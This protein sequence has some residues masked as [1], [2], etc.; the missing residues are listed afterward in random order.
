MPP[1]TRLLR[2]HKEV[3]D[4]P[5]RLSL[6]VF[7]L[8]TMS[9]TTMQ[10]RL[11]QH[12]ETN[13]GKVFSNTHGAQYEVR[14]APLFTPRPVRII[15]IG[16]GASGI[17]MIHT[18]RQALAGLPFEHIVFEKNKGVGGTWFENR[19]PGCRADVPSHSYQ[20]S[21]RKNPEWSSLFAPAA[22]IE[23]YLRTICEE[24]GM[25]EC[26]RTS[27]KVLSAVWSEELAVWRM[28]VER[29]ET[30]EILLEDADFLIDASGILK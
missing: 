13:G 2:L 18:L 28:E 25:W 26:I 19:Y 14:E 29:L 27:H 4:F 6:P 7:R 30:G 24:E 21:W 11:S 17:N 3:F 8:R 5:P 12:A 1:L 20:F 10:S 9:R 23:A 16:A 22:E 15:G